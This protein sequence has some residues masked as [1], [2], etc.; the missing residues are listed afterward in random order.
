MIPQY[1]EIKYAVLME[2]NGKELESWYYFI[3]YNGNE[4]ALK[5]LQSQLEMV[6]EWYILDDLSTFDLDLENLVSEQTAKEMT[7]LVLNAVSGHRKFDGTLERITFG[8]KPKD[9]NDKKLVRCFKT[10]GIGRIDEFIDDEDYPSDVEMDTGS[11]GSDESGSSGTEYEYG[12][13]DSDEETSSEEE[14]ERRP[15]KKEKGTTNPSKATVD[16]IKEEL[17]AKKAAKEALEKEKEKAKEKDRKKEDKSEKK[18]EKD[19][20]E[21]KD[22]GKK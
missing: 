22:K 7:Y 19:K 8:F 5:H 9:S 18:K 20:S 12:L 17:K 6:E 2:T 16:K 4:E 15:S 1:E 14:E 21:K 13:S 11:D 10:I 3:K